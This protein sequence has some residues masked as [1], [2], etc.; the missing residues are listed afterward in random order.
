M[1]HSEVVKNRKRILTASATIVL[2]ATLLFLPGLPWSG[3]IRY[4]IK[5]WA[6]KLETT[7]ADL[8][9]QHPRTVSLAGKL[10]GSGAFVEAVK[11]ARIDALESG[12]GYAAMSDGDG[13]FVLP[14]LTWYPSATFTLFI[15]V[16]Q[17]QARIV[18]VR[19]PSTCP[20]DG[21]I[22]MG[23]LSFD[24]GVETD[25]KDQPDRYL[26][27]DSQNRR[28]YVEMF[29][30][31]TAPSR[32]DDQKI[33][34]I[35]GYVATRRNPEQRAL[36]FRSAR[37][38]LERG[39]PH[40]SHLAFAMAAITAA[41]GYPTR[42]VHLT[43]TPEYNHTHVAVEVFYESGWH[44]YDPTYG[45]SFFNR[46][47]T[48]ASYK[49]LRLTPALITLD[50]FRQPSAFEREALEWMPGAY[51]SG[52]YQVYQVCEAGFVDACPFV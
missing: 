6:A 50:A 39:A 46:N 33:K 10:T 14:H 34:A 16:N 40:C 23:D 26:R 24:L 19:A 21:V 3:R 15:S 28:Y 9:G 47:G 2:V 42:T 37:Q 29:E 17:Y 11:G 18:K 52:L 31:L 22:D 38:V 44:L 12:S 35:A 8:R 32:T 20:T 25:A 45:I 1:P 5:R 51:G 49:E 30:R 13:R 43:D 48:V 7:L 27:Y 4:A 36:S 41:G